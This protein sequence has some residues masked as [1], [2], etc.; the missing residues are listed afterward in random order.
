V[1]L[2]WSYYCQHDAK[3]LDRAEAIWEEVIRKG[4]PADPW[5]EES[6]WHMIQ[7]LAGPRAKWKEAVAH[8]DAAAKGA[9]AGSFRHEQ[10][11]YT[12]AWLLWTQKK[13]ALSLAGFK[14][15]VKAYPP[16]ATHPPI[17]A[18]MQEC[19]KHIAAGKDE[20]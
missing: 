16:K 5:V 3:S 10:A 12:R 15:F 7:L 11:L 13:W 9:L 6:Q 18:Y 4:P 1:K 20:G 17:M 14:E 19:E 8:C 2:G